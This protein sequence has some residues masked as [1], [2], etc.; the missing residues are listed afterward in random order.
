MAKKQRPRSRS[1]DLSASVAD[2]QN[3]VARNAGLRQVSRF[4]QLAG[5]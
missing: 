3:P 4:Q 5:H 1:D 2:L